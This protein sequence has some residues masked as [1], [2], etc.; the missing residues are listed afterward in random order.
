[1]VSSRDAFVRAID[2]HRETLDIAR[3]LV[4][5]ASPNPPGDTRAVAEVAAA[6]L[7]ELVPDL[8]VALYPASDRIVNVVARLRATQ[9]GKRV[10]MNGHLD[11]YPVG[12]ESRWSV[13][14]YG[15]TVRDGRLYGRG[16][17]DMKG[18]IAASIS[19]LAMLAK[20]RD[21]W[22]GEAVLVLA[23]DEETMGPLGTEW[24][25]K[26]VPHARGDAVIIGDVGSPEVLR[27]GE[28]GFLWIELEATGTAAH[29]AHV[30]LGVNAIDRLRAGLDRLNALRDTAVRS[31]EAVTRAI[32]LAAPVS[33]SLSG[34]GEA[35]TLRHVTVNVGW[36]EGGISMNLVPAKAMAMLDI[37]LPVGI[38][39]AEMETTLGSLL[40]ALPGVNWRVL[41]RSEPTY[42]DPNADIVRCTVAAAAKL[43][44]HP[45]VVNM[46]VGGCDA[47]LYRRAGIPA[48]VYGPTPFN[49]GGPDEYVLADELNVVAKVHAL[50][51]LDFLSR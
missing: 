34:T 21:L 3:R 16:A 36:I 11:T 8:E 40:G 47:R 15:G 37:R 50:A 1:M 13:D 20:Q 25:I 49:M 9:P 5:V 41:R 17:A 44:G 28:K 31:P 43:L 35:E 38:S 45:P 23:G 51:S 4:S 24:L 27:F 18:G 30:H 42:T 29:G 33:E 46:R 32:A 14:P 10:V 48:I 19:A 26:H 22:R 7:R 39:T 2:E 6:A 12:D